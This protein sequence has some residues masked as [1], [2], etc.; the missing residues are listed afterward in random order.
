MNFNVK[1]VT[2]D[3]IK[4]IKKYYDDNNIGGAVIGLSGGKDSSVCLAL[5]AK[6]IGSK[7][8]LALWL[9][10]NSKES[11]KKDAYQL[12]EKFNIEIKEFDLFNYVNNFINDMKLINKVDDNDLIDTSINLK[13]R[14]RMLTLYSYAAMMTKIKNKVY[15]VIGTSNKSER[16]VGYF[17]KGGD[18]VCDIAPITD[19]YVD[20]VVAIGDYLG[21]PKRITHKTPDDGLSGLSDEEKLGFSYQDVKKVSEELENNIVDDSIDNEIRKKIIRKHQANLHKFNIPFYKRIK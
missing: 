15:L 4:F 9:P 19:L 21:V 20:E 6:A 13:P 7:N 3:I 17:T 11:D 12:A 2:D 8:I 18:S 1:E 5:M 10:A 14:L 16:F